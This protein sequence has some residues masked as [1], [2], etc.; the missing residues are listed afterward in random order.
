M[1]P[2]TVLSAAEQV[3]KHLRAELLRGS[4]SGTMPGVYPMAAELGAELAV[5][6][7]TVDAACQLERPAH[8]ELARA[9]G[10]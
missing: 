2:F 4:L 7:K 1:Q 5:N 8:G 3:A 9:L 6:H 10:L